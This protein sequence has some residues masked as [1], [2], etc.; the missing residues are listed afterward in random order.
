MWI[1]VVPSHSLAWYHLVPRMAPTFVLDLVLGP[2]SLC[3]EWPYDVDKQVK[4]SQS[5]IVSLIIEIFLQVDKHTMYISR[6]CSLHFSCTWRAANIMLIVLR[7]AR[8]P[9]WLSGKTLS[10]RCR[11]SRSSRMRV[12][13]SPAIHTRYIP[14]WLAFNAFV[15]FPFVDVNDGCVLE[16]LRNNPAVTDIVE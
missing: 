9:H 14:R 1:T 6:F 16:L 2:P 12:S 8:N 7:Y 3:V 4:G 15:T 5:F 10:A 11:D 13:I